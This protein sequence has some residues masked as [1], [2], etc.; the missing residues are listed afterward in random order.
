MGHSNGICCSEG[1]ARQGET[2]VEDGILLW[3]GIGWDGMGWDGIANG[4]RGQRV[5]RIHKVKKKERCSSAEMAPEI[6]ARS[7]HGYSSTRFINTCRQLFARLD[8]LL[9]KSTTDWPAQ[10]HQ[11]TI[12]P[13]RP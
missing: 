4:Q 13:P 6:Y 2:V 3:S 8:K 10:R 12:L 1:S 11:H 9:P 7:K 5:G